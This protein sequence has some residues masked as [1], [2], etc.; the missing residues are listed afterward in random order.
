MRNS[1][2]AST[3]IR[4]LNKD[5]PFPVAILLDTKG[6][7]IRTHTFQEGAVK[8]VTKGSRPCTFTMD[9]RVGDETSFSVNY[10]NLIHDVK[11]GTHDIS[12]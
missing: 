2:S 7:E 5:V 6:P 10:P 4:Q 12:G 1:W 9:E 11:V 8:I 3:L